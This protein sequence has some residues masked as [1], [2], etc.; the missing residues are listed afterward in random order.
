MSTTYNGRNNG[1]GR[2]RGGG[3][4]MREEA[5]C[6][7]GVGKEVERDAILFRCLVASKLT[8]ISFSDCLLSHVDEVGLKMPP[9][10][11]GCMNVCMF[12]LCLALFPALRGLLKSVGLSNTPYTHCILFNTRCS[13]RPPNH[14]APIIKQIG[15]R[16]PGNCFPHSILSKPQ[17][18]IRHRATHRNFL[19]GNS[20]IDRP[21]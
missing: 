18:L 16:R 17:T 13:A 11:A 4:E 3:D 9:E 20:S 21:T 1:Q 7:S 15:K 5:E 10:P 2:G 12:V 14:P 6:R 8:I 19:G